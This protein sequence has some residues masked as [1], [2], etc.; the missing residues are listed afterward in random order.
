MYILIKV[1]G[2]GFEYKKE[3]KKNLIKEYFHQKK[4]KNPGD[5]CIHIDTACPV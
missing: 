2:D 4:K 1:L 3:K 5:V